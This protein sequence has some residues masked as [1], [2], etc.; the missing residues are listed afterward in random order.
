M[1]KPNSDSDSCP[2][3]STQ[4]WESGDMRIRG[5]FLPVVFDDGGD[6]SFRK[7]K[8]VMNA[9]ACLGCGYVELYISK[10]NQ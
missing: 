7:R 9:R 6:F 5:Y 2:K 8:R 4:Q 1:D 10:K 3:C